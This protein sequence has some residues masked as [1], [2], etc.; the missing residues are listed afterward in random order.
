MDDDDHYTD[1]EIDDAFTDKRCRCGDGRWLM[2]KPRKPVDIAITPLWTAT[3]DGA[4]RVVRRGLEWQDCPNCRSKRKPSGK[5]CALCQRDGL[6]TDEDH[7]Y[8]PE[9][10]PTMTLCL[11]CHKRRTYAR[12]LWNRPN[13]KW[14]LAPNL[15]AKHVESLAW[16]R[17]EIA[18]WLSLCLATFAPPPS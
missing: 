10:G 18:D 5:R 17:A 16:H 15:E 9:H 14:W 2:L 7:I 4:V 6:P 11:S 12:S 8:H 1:A 3:P 13:R